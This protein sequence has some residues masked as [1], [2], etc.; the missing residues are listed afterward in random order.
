MKC[1][2]QDALDSVSVHPDTL[3]SVVTQCF[4]KLVSARSSAR[5]R[6]RA[7]A[8]L[9]HLIA[10][11]CLSSGISD[12]EGVLFALQDTFECNS[13]F[14]GNYFVLMFIFSSTMSHASVDFNVYDRARS[15]HWE[16]SHEL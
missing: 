3:N 16:S 9:E 6:G 12:D 13:E 4:L 2:L 14:V 5:R 15:T 1:T 10:L 8:A 7:L 11:E